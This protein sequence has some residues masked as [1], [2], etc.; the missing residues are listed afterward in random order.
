MNAFVGEAIFV[1]ADHTNL[2]VGTR[3]FKGLLAYLGPKPNPG[4]LQ[5]LDQHGAEFEIRPFAL[6]A[7]QSQAATGASRRPPGVLS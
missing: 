6:P 1:E 7:S 3:G 5:K 4:L 2:K